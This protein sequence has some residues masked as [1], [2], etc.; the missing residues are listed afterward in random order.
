M[1]ADTWAEKRD[2]GVTNWPLAAGFWLLASFV[3]DLRDLRYQCALF[4]EIMKEMKEM[5]K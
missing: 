5:K 3:F 2:E 4:N 1:N